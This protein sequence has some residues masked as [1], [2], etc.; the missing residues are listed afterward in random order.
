MRINKKGHLLIGDID[1]AELVK[2]FSTPLY[3]LDEAKVRERCGLLR[4]TLKSAYPDSSVAYASKALSVLALYKIISDEG[5]RIDVVSG[6]E[7]YAA[8]RAGVDPKAI[9]MHGNNKL[10]AEI[11]YVVENGIDIIVIDGADEAEIID[12]AAKKHGITQNVMVRV[13]PVITAVTHGHVQTAKIDS[14]FGFLIENG[15]ADRAIENVLSYK[16]LKFLG[17]HCHIGSQILDIT[18]FVDTVGVMIDYIKHIKDNLNVE[19]TELNVGGGFG[20]YYADG[21]AIIPVEDFARRIGESVDKACEERGIKKPHLVIEPGRSIVAEAGTTLYTVGTI[22]EVKEI[23]KK[24]YAVD[25]GMFDNPRHALYGSRYSAV[26]ANKANEPAT[27]LVT[28]AGKCCESG[29]IIATDVRLQKAERG[30]ILAVFNTGAFNF[31]M[32]SNYN[33]N[34]RPAMVLVTGDK[35]E[36]IVRP[37]SYEDIVSRQF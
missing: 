5:L 36:Y 10:P 35:A 2:S 13:N 4:D 12:D 21:D 32:S 26:L 17:I 16:N 25:G 22:K 1:A 30:D 7:F 9:I 29:D 20:I 8:L 3:V 37:E 31:S 6:G 24:Y 34:P 14:K 11:E 18:P 28:I 15:D 19:M 23:G 33:N 27:E